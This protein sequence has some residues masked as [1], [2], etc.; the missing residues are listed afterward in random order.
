MIEIKKAE[1]ELRLLR[2][3]MVN[4]GYPLW[5][6]TLHDHDETCEVSCE[7]PYQHRFHLLKCSQC[8][9]DIE[10]KNNFKLVTCVECRAKRMAELQVK[11]RL[12]AKNKQRI[13]SL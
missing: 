10:R 2:N 1:E 13:I 3:D 5:W 11:R 6:R 7:I 12:L 4:Q 8:G 9:K